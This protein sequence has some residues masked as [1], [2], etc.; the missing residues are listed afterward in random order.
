MNIKENIGL[1]IMVVSAIGMTIA[2]SIDDIHFLIYSGFYLIFSVLIIILVELEQQ[3][4]G[5]R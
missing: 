5:Y 3:K 2:V 1:M 4:E